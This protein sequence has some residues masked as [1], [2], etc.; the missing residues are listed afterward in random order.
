MG[1]AGPRQ[2]GLIAVNRTTIALAFIVL[3]AIGL[4]GGIIVHLLNPEAQATWGNFVFTILGLATTAAV[5]IGGLKV[6]NDK[7]DQVQQQTNGRL[8]QK[9]DELTKKDRW[10]LAAGIDP[11][12]GEPMQPQGDP[13]QPG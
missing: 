7:I 3:A 8:S 12:T 9:D 1:R 5:T 6:V 10:L 2:E 4:V 13:Q 11:Q